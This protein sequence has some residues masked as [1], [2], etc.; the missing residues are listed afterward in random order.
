MNNK[1]ISSL[2]LYFILC[3]TLVFLILSCSSSQVADAT[4]K[5]SPEEP[6]PKQ[7]VWNPA[8]QCCNLHSESLGVVVLSKVC[9]SQTETRLELFTKESKKVC[10][11]KEGMVFQDDLGT[12]YSFV[13][14]V[15]VGLCPKRTQMKNTPFSI[16]FDSISPEAKSF[17][18]IENKNAKHANKPWSFEKVDLSTCTW[19]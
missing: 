19:N 17:D 14:S 18:L 8:P 7:R 15:G 1:Q 5:E 16:Y 3:N 4:V 13:K 12:P 11:L 10:V 2:N 6:L 9:V